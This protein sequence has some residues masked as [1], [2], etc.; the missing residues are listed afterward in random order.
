MKTNDCPSPSDSDI[1]SFWHAHGGRQHGPHVETMTIEERKFYPLMR[2]FA[3][4]MVEAFH[5]AVNKRAES[6]MLAGN[7]VTGAHHRALEAEI[8]K[9]K[10]R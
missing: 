10:S 6:D 2:M 1:N 5:Q 9:W 8:A 7:P 4:V 3:T